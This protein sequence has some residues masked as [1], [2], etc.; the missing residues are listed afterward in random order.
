VESEARQPAGGRLQVEERVLGPAQPELEQ[1]ER[2]PGLLLD[3]DEAVPLGELVDLDGMGLTGLDLA[4]AGLDPGQVT[5]KVDD[6]DRLSKL[7]REREPLG[8][9]RDG[10]V[11]PSCAGAVPAHLGE[12]TG[13]PGRP[14]LA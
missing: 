13:E 11:P 4:A 9:R 6:V 3:D 2:G 7:A 12:R 14:F 8:R 5:E 10:P 1:A